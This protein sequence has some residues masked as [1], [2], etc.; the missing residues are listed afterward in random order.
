MKK[1]I[2]G[3]VF[4]TM[5]F[6]GCSFFKKDPQ[7]VVD[8]GVSKIAEIKKMSSLLVMS[9]AIQS[10]AG[11]IP[12]KVKFSIQVS[13]KTDTTDKDSPKVDTTMKLEGNADDQKVSAE[14]MFRSV[15]KQMYIQV[16]NVKISGEAGK[17]IE[18]QLGSL[19]NTWW[20]LPLGAQNPIG[21]FT[22]RQ[23]E[24]Q[25]L[26]KTTK[27]F[28]NAKEEGEEDV[29]GVKS[30]RYRVDLDK[31]ALKKFIFDVARLSGNQVSPEE[32][33]ALGES[34]KDIEFS[35]AVWVGDDDYLHRV[36]GT[37]AVAPKDGPSSTFDVDYSSWD[38]GKDVEVG[39]P[40]GAKEFNPLMLFP[41]MG[42][43]G[44]LE[45]GV[46]GAPEAVV[47]EPLGAAQVTPPPAAVPKE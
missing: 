24:L 42:A 35:G 14:L 3:L 15:N 7:K 39:V 29:Q 11:E 18:G 34:L 20:S 1:I 41:L 2:A 17:A 36:K 37:V 21:K 22:S 10:P 45:Q 16:G 4:V 8:E 46:A 33:L 5:L 28:T 44:S 26:F 30:V 47:D 25:D 23:Q 12:G 19:L 43:F 6:S 40:E 32:E 38:Y 9:G 31:E 13:G 27:F